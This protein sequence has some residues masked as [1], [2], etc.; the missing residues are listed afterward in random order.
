MGVSQPTFSQSIYL[1]KHRVACDWTNSQDALV[2]IYVQADEARHYLAS[3]LLP[4]Y[5][6]TTLFPL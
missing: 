2:R 4:Y 5:S 6:V 3:Y 1:L